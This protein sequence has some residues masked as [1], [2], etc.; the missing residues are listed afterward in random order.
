VRCSFPH[1][2]EAYA[3]A[4]ELKS[5]FSRACCRG[6][7]RNA[8]QNILKRST[9]PATE[10]ESAKLQIASSRRSI[11]ASSIMIIICSQTLRGIVV[12]IFGLIVLVATNV[13]NHHG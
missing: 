3:L 6:R 7:S 4:S 9:L 10:R 8:R 12:A 1:T 2:I 13:E 11:V 5:G